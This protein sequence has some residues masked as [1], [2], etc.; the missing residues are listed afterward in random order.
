MGFRRVAKIGELPA[1][2]G[3]CVT[4]DGVEVGLFRANGRVFAMENRCPHAGIPLSEGTLRGSVVTC[5][6]HGWAFD[7]RTGHRPED[8]DGF[9]IPCF[10][11]KLEGEAILVDLDT[12]T[13][14]PPRR[15]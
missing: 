9:P 14:P 1:G 8:P 12:S 5:R 10:A 2:R 15:R 13:N 3:L 4:I 6:A 7:L 11:V